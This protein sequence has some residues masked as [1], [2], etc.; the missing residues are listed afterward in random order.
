[1]RLAVFLT[2]VSFLACS[3]F[4]RIFTEEAV[5]RKRRVIVKRRSRCV[6]QWEHGWDLAMKIINS[7]PK[8]VEEQPIYQHCLTILDGAFVDGD[9]LRFELGLSALTDFY[10]DIINAGDCQPWWSRSQGPD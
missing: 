5:V 3:C 7:V 4:K 1:M 6:A 9:G 8:W 2:L 10:S